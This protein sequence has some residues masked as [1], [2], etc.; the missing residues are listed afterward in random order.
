MQLFNIK[1]GKEIGLIKTALKE[2]IL[3]G[4]ISNDYNE[5]QKFVVEQGKKLGLQTP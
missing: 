5:A 2:A 4:I 1:P 3:D